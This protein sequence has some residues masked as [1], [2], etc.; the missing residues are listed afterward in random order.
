MCHGKREKLSLKEKNLADNQ[1][2]RGERKIEKGCS[3]R[4]KLSAKEKYSWQKRSR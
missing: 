4:K 1:I 2:K 3:E